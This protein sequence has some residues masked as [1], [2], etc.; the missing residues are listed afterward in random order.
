MKLLIA[1]PAY[2]E[3][4]TIVANAR[5]LRRFCDDRMVGV[6]CVIIIADNA[7]TD[8]TSEI[9]SRLARELSGVRHLRLEKKGKGLAIREAWRSESADL[10]AF[11]DADLSADL[12]ALPEMLARFFGGADVV[13][14]S[15]AL[16]GST[17]AR[18]K[19]RRL[20]SFGYRLL[21]R[22]LLDARL[23][24]AS[25]GCKAV[26][27]RVVER[28]APEVADERWFFDTELVVRAMRAG[29]RV[30]EIPVHWTDQRERRSKVSPAAVAL[31][32]VSA[33]WR[34]RREII[35]RRAGE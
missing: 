26:S 21:L 29:F 14:G 7:S 4:P 33:V 2:N 13:V 15:R 25:C 22:T 8:G 32:Y 11:M 27:R 12:D 31:E 3:A 34:L 20:Y 6:E 24:D 17:A 28:V 10:Y 30:D 9:A 19:R 23:S 18:R 5:R 16:A 1:V 35:R